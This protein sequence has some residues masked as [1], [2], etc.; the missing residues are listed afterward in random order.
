MTILSVYGIIFDKNRRILLIRHS[1]G[2]KSW[3]IPGDRPGEGESPIEGLVR[4]IDDEI[5][6]KIKPI[7]LLGAYST[8]YNDA[9]SLSIEAEVVEPDEWVP[10]EDVSDIGFFAAFDLPYPIHYITQVII[11]DAFE[12]RTGV[13]RVFSHPENTDKTRLTEE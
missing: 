11:Q 6:A 8:T 13:I 10:G 1:L 9:L 2:S 7:R 12:G 5:H 3:T 4:I